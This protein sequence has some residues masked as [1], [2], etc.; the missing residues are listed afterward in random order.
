MYD[1]LSHTRHS[2]K[3]LT[4]KKNIHNFCIRFFFF[5]N[6]EQRNNVEVTISWSKNQK[7]PKKK[8]KM[9]G[10]KKLRNCL[11]KFVHTSFHS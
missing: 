4:A 6:A 9:K 11:N 8:K 1:C 3:T 5:G 7:K 2:Y 10:K